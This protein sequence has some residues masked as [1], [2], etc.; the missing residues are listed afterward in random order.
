M[1]RETSH[2]F[3]ACRAK[4]RAVHVRDQV[5]HCEVIPARFQPPQDRSHIFI[6]LAGLDGAEKGVLENPIERKRRGIMEKVREP[7]LST[8]TGGFGPL[9]RMP[10]GA[11]RNVISVRSETGAGPRARIMT[12]SAAGHANG[13]SLQLRMRG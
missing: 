2:D 12:G 6:P 9:Y 10:H 11:R 1:W 8:Q 13:A 5:I 3:L 4:R 7:K